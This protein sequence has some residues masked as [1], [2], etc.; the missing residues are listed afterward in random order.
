MKI[1]TMSGSST[2]DRSVS[3]AVETLEARLL[4]AGEQSK[5]PDP[6][7]EHLYQLLLAM[8]GQ[9]E[10]AIHEFLRTLR[11][12]DGETAAYPTA[13]ALKTIT[14]QVLV[15]LKDEGLEKSQL[16]KEVRGA[17]GLAFAMEVYVLG[18][19]R[20]V[21]QPMGDEAWEKSEW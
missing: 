3:P 17:N 9:G 8:E 2:L 4:A 19:M 7:F 5:R 12:A 11:G 14:Q 6:E 20:D 10:K 1:E 15:R 18:V 13:M 21:F 16:Y